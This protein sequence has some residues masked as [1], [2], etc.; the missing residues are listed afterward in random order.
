[1]AAA[2]GTL[3][4]RL[5][6]HN[7][8]WRRVEPH[9]PAEGATGQVGRWICLFS[10]LSRWWWSSWRLANTEK[11][12]QQTS[13]NFPDLLFSAPS[14]LRFV[15]SSSRGGWVVHGGLLLSFLLSPMVTSMVTWK[16]KTKKHKA[17]STTINFILPSDQ[18]SVSSQPVLLL[19]SS[20]FPH[21][22]WPY[23]DLQ[24]PNNKT[25]RHA[26]NSSWAALLF[27]SRS[28]L[29]HSSDDCPRGSGRGKEPS[30]V[31]T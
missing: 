31:A 13:Q 27:F 12:K 10:S 26:I 17:T 21:R 20:S 23:G 9:A 6:T 8:H 14:D 7:H 16:T 28:A 30:W 24:N 4:A 22:R 5:L 11:H 15:P 3:V 19:L 25:Q 29:I 1:M 2:I 18:R